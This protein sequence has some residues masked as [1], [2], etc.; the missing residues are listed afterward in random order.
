MMLKSEVRE[1]VCCF[2][3]KHC[4]KIKKKRDQRVVDW[5]QAARANNTQHK[6]AKLY[7]P[8]P[9]SKT[10]PPDTAEKVRGNRICIC[11]AALQSILRIKK[12]AWRTIHRT[13]ETTGEVPP[14][15]N[16]GR[17]NGR[18]KK[19]YDPVVLA[20]KEFMDHLKTLGEPRATRFVRGEIGEMT[21]RDHDD[22]AVWLP[23][24]HGVRAIVSDALP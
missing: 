18:Q 2:L 20:L 3:F 13:L 19:P 22:K 11:K 15:G 9:T 1:S 24:T 23:M 10:L 12:K 14:H 6:N 4:N 5:V 17:P 16:T 7:F 8:Y 21:L